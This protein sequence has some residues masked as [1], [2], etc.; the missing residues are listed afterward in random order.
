MGMTHKC[1]TSR[2]IHNNAL[3]IVVVGGM[4]LY[5]GQP[6]EVLEQPSIKN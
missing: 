2:T 6:R 3:Y 4:T 5:L 1:L